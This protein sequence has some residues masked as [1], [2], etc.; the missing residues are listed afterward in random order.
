M[1]RARCV[2]YGPPAIHIEA[3]LTTI[4]VQAEKVTFTTDMDGVPARRDVHLDLREHPPNLT[5]T[6]G[7]HS[8]G[9]WEQGTLVID[10][11]GFTAHEEGFG[12]GVPSSERK[13]LVERFGLS[14]DGRQLVYTTTI[15]DP[16]VL[17]E[18]VTVEARLDYRPDLT[19]NDSGCDIG[20]A[21]RYLNEP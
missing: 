18:P 2:P 13:H 15:V 9:R 21:R 7:G 5:A 17:T 20:A 10:T 6:F 14:A 8:I 11:V 16:E 4:E 1:S 12:F 19:S 3:V